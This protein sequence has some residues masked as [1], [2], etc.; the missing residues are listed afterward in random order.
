MKVRCATLDDA[1]YLAKIHVDSWRAAYRGLVPDTHL[2]SLDYDRRT[3]DFR[4]WIEAGDAEIYLVELNWHSP[5]SHTLS[6]RIERLKIY[7]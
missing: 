5:R 7:I 1:S 2:K 6:K 3:E 4:K